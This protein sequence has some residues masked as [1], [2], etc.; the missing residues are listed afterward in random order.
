[1]DLSIATRQS[2]QRVATDR[3]S[4]CH[5]APHRACSNHTSPQ[6][7]RLPA[8]PAARCH[9]SGIFPC[10]L[11][12]RPS[13]SKEIRPLC[14]ICYVFRVV[15]QLPT[16][17]FCTL[18]FAASW[19]EQPQLPVFPAPHPRFSPPDRRRHHGSLYGRSLRSWWSWHAA[20]R[21]PNTR[22]TVMKLELPAPD[23]YS[24]QHVRC[25]V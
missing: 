5:A 23:C 25:V 15:L 17:L 3:L 8:V 12:K 4:K 13:Q 20:G 22:S 6:L 10:R 7:S 1:M 16:A 18:V 21:C 2:L 24:S 14:V 11:T 9:S 19:D